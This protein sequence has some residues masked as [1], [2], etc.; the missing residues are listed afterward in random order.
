VLVL[1]KQVEELTELDAEPS[2]DLKRGK[3]AAAFSMKG[4]DCV[5]LAQHS[6]KLAV[7]CCAVLC[8]AVQVA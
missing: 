1:L 3:K 2:C 4:H 7:L 8:C 6:D 5:S